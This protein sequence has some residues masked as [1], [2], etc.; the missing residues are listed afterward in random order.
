MTSFFQLFLKVAT[1]TIITNYFVGCKADEQQS[2]TESLDNFAAGKNTVFTFNTCR[3]TN[4]VQVNDNQLIASSEQKAEIRFALSAVPVEL[5]TAF[6]DTLKGSIKIVKNINVSCKNQ[7]VDTG[8]DA[9]LAC[10]QPDVDSATI[11]IKAED[12]DSDTLRNISHSVVRAMGYILTD[13][14]LKA[15]KT[16]EGTKLKDNAAFIQVKREL[17]E[18]LV[19][20]LRAGKTYQIPAIFKTDRAEF[21]KGAFAESFD[22]WYCW[23]ESREKMAQNFSNTYGY[24]SDI[25]AILPEALSADVSSFVS[26]EP[27][28]MSLWGRWGGG[29]GPIRQGFAN[30][31]GFRAEGGGLMNFRRF[32]DGGGLVFQRPWFNPFRWE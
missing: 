22:S 4:P 13:V 11:Y 20:D 16:K 6:F 23:P 27:A 26:T 10:W 29:N 28:G 14:V 18:E 32:N 2:N 19:K 8:R 24:F 30:W 1:V 5:Q 25:A 7:R 31:G 21:D 9:T 15:N 12:N 17:A 3:G